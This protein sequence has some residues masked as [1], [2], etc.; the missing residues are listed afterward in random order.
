MKQKT[1]QK[2]FTAK[3]FERY[4]PDDD[5]C[6]EWIKNLRYPNGIECPRCKKV[7]KHY[8]VANRPVYECGRCWHQVSPLANTIFHK[9]T[10]PLKIW[11]D[12][13]HEMSTTRTGFSAM[14]LQRK[15]GITYKT[16]W[17][18]FKQIRTLLDESTGIFTNEVEVD[19]TYI[20]G[21][22]HG[23]R[24]RGAEGK[25]AVIGIAQ[26]HGKVISQV[27]ADTKRST[28]M[29]LITKNVAKKAI[30]YTDEYPVYDGVGRL[31]VM[32]NKKYTTK[33]P[34]S[35]YQE[36]YIQFPCKLYT[37]FYISRPGGASHGCN[38]A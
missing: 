29:P 8:K 32:P 21:M 10:T 26:R 27:V 14:A 38:L 22:R 13:I 5:A 35:M 7:T 31:G 25:T 6:L 9:S 3:D 30:I 16:A 19:E 23:T 33:W 34:F 20:G 24:G 37:A 15:H 1:R 36:L 11:F 12:A 17:R 4:F 28:V 2:K 18:M